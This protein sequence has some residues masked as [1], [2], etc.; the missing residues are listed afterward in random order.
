[1]RA[2]DRRG[3]EERRARFHACRTV[4]TLPCSSLT[5]M[6]AAE[7]AQFNTKAH[8]RRNKVKITAYHDRMLVALMYLDGITDEG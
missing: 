1:M 5:P 7:L 8:E 6:E 4:R 3:I 2:V